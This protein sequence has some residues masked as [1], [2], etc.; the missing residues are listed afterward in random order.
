MSNLELKRTKFEKIITFK[1]RERRVSACKRAAYSF[2][3]GKHIFRLLN[4]V[5]V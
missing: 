2:Y 3:C 5:N 1:L 4:F